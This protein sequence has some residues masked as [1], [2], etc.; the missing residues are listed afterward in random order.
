M[1]RTTVSCFSISNRLYTHWRK[2][3]LLLHSLGHLS[4]HP[5]STAYPIRGRGRGGQGPIPAYWGEGWVTLDKSPVRHRADKKRKTIIHTNIHTCEQFRGT[6]LRVFGMWEE[7][8]EPGEN[9]R[10][11]REKRPTRESNPEPSCCE[12]SVLTT[13]HLSRLFG[14]FM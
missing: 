3:L 7:A 5:F 8:G 2:T 11:T 1:S 13:A 12:A 4:I 14:T 9:P 10:R 6:S